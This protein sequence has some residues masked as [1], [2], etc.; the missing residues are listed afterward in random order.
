MDAHSSQA[1]K[2]HLQDAHQVDVGLLLDDLSS[3]EEGL[4]S[5]EAHRRLITYG[6]NVLE[7]KKKKSELVKF[8]QQFRN[9]FAVLLL[10]GGLLALLAERLEPGQGNLYIAYALIAVVLLNAIFTYIQEHQTERIMESFS[11][12]LPQ[13]VTVLRDGQPLSIRADA[14]VPGDVMI[15]SEGDRICADG[16]LLEHS[17]LKIDLSSLTGESEP[18]LRHLEATSSNILESRNMVFSGTLVQS[19]DGKAVIYSTGMDTQLGHVVKLTKETEEVETPIRRE[20]RRFTRIIGFIAIVLG[21][22]FFVISVAIGKGQIDS[23]IFAIGIIV[24]NVP[25]G[26]LPTVTLALTMASRRMAKKKALVKNLESIETLGSTTV[27]CTDKTGTLTQ[28]RIR[29]STVILNRKEFVAWDRMIIKQP[30]AKDILDAMVLCNN[31]YLNHDG[32]SGDPTEGALLVY[33]NGLVDV[34]QIKTRERFNELPF[35]SSTKRMITVNRDV[36][37][38]GYLAWL[39]GAPEVVL[40]K[41]SSYLLE[42]AQEEMNDAMRRHFIADFQRLAKRGE[43]VLALA[44]RTVAETTL[45]DESGFILIGLIGMQDPPRPEVPD[46]IQRCRRAGIK[47]IMITGDYDITAETI[48]RQVGL[49]KGEGVVIRG[50][51]LL[52]MADEQLQDSLQQPEIVFARTN[53]DQKLRIVRMLQAQGEVVSV[54]GDGVNDAPALKNADMGVAMGIMGTDVAKEASDMVLMDDNFATIVA[55]VEEGRTIFENIKKFIAYILTSN[56]PE[57]LPFIAYVV[58][59][60]PLPLTVVL[61]LAIDLGTDILPALGLGS[62]RPESDVMKRPPR[63]RQERLLTPNL[64]FRS[65]AVVGMIQAAAGFFSYFIVLLNGGWQWGFELAT[66]DP[67]YRTAVT[68]FFASIVF[69]QVANVLICRTR[70]QSLFSVGILTNRLVLLGIATELLL[71]GLISYVPICNSFF[72]TAPLQAWQLLLSVPFAVLIFLGD[73][74]RRMYVR[75]ENAFVLKWLNW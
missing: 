47:V 18:Q 12:M 51:E 73:E 6:A 43:R 1:D 52:T 66:T 56:V 44:Y 45:S 40:Q 29:V 31:A 24:A 55:A 60:I 58:L 62:E 46:A 14:V 7:G 69:C 42:G 35:D 2:L 36:D 54:T 33:A 23:L 5:A 50:D 71:L 16:R 48:A 59:D 65:Y 67:L 32:F 15:L 11:R 70:R 57:I 61:I 64:L 4:S 68:A 21:V 63:S 28:N 41:C 20:L 10:V 27:I 39:K 22:L 26:L 53:P 19:G 25:E 37:P 72:G 38:D 75:R 49:I 13:M 74:L 17:Q 30:G 3:S 9:Y 34:A 8:L